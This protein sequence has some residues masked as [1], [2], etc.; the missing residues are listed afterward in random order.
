VT[1]SESAA[2]TRSAR[3][4]P[5]GVVMAGVAIGLALAVVGPDRWRMGCVV[6][7]ASLVFG[8]V[9]RLVLPRNSA[10]LL[11]VRSKPFDVIAMSLA[12]VAVVGLA[13]L[14]PPGR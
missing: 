14:V 3:V 8:A 4:W 7:G 13:L 10:G 6:M 11:E 2:S 5:L 12:G 1:R 9:V